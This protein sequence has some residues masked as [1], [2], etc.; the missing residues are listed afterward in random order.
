LGRQRTKEPSLRRTNKQT[1]LL[2]N[3]ELQALNLYCERYRISKSEFMREAIMRTILERFDHD[4][5][6]LFEESPTLFSRTMRK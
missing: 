6:S 1:I 3:R 4:L 2:N 5:P